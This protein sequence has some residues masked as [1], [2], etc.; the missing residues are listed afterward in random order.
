NQLLLNSA[1]EDAGL[2]VNAAAPALSGTSL[3]LLA[4]KYME[5]QA[6]I[7]RWSR[8]YDD[9][10]LEQLIYMPE[11]KPA[12]FDRPEWRRGWAGDLDGRLNALAD[13][14]RSYR[15]EVRAASPGQGARV[16]VHK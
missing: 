13:G 15:V 10:M 7:K 16:T 8:R 11:V 1:L 12:D 14:T 9:R 2:H 4:R 3:E 6:I 5:V